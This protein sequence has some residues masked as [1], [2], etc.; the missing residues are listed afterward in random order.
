MPNRQHSA[1]CFRN[2]Q[3]DN[4]S[5]AFLLL[6]RQLAKNTK[7]IFLNDPHFQQILNLKKNSILVFNLSADEIGRAAVSSILKFE[8]RSHLGLCFVV[9]SAPTT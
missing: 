5:R 2:N 4:I 9:S 6:L 7:L 3:W 8:I 1:V